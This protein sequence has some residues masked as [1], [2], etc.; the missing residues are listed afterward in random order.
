MSSRAVVNNSTHQT[1]AHSISNHP[2][3]TIQDD[4]QYLGKLMSRIQLKA[5]EW[6]FWACSS[7]NSH[8]HWI[9]ASL[10]QLKIDKSIAARK[11]LRN[12][13]SEYRK[14]VRKSSLGWLNAKIGNPNLKYSL[15]W[16]YSDSNQSNRTTKKETAADRV[17]KV[18]IDK[19]K[20]KMVIFRSSLKIFDIT[21]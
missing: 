5:S 2:E 21:I 12:D 14:L 6:Q 8:K 1:W 7:Q 13:Y 15:A 10:R 17:F 11:E 18:Q 3:P 20:G 4:G 9:P 19:D 16:A